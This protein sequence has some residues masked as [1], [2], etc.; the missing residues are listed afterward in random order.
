[1]QK[2]DDDD[3]GPKRP[4]AV[5]ANNAQRTPKLGMTSVK[6]AARSNP[7]A[8]HCLVLYFE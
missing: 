5:R 3:E 4:D 8:R 1:R 2:W 7:R 6:S